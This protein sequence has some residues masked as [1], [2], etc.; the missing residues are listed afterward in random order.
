MIFWCPS[1]RFLFPHWYHEFFNLIL[2]LS[3]QIFVHKIISSIALPT[4]RL[5]YTCTSSNR[6]YPA[7]SLAFMLLSEFITGLI[8]ICKKITCLIY[9]TGCPLRIWWSLSLSKHFVFC[10][11]RILMIVFIRARSWIL[12]WAS[13][14]QSTLPHSI[15]LWSIL[16]LAPIYALVSQV[17]SSLK[18]SDLYFY[19]LFL[20]QIIL[21]YSSYIIIPDLTV[22]IIDNFNQNNEWGWQIFLCRP[23]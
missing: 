2:I 21:I 12:L 7:N 15:S 13:W 4:A 5:S 22:I 11:T 3:Y 9:W 8:R 6:V 20:F 14:A 16:I 17:V 10:E 23:L 19:E 1:C 18:V